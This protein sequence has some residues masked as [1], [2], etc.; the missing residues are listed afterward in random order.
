MLPFLKSLVL[1]ELA[2]YHFSPRLLGV[3]W[4]CGEM[5]AAG[6]S[7]PGEG[8]QGGVETHSGHRH[9]RASIASC[10]GLGSGSFS[11][12]IP[13]SFSSI[14]VLPSQ[15]YALPVHYAFLPGTG[16]APPIHGSWLQWASC[17]SISRARSS[18]VFKLPLPA[19]PEGHCWGRGS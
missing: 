16:E 3:M 2:W 8:T 14:S 11:T 1:W 6:L 4:Q 17:Y 7:S 13:F 12:Y 19:S 9:S 15:D 5:L 18:L 10:P